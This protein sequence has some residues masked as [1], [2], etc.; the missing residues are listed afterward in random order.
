MLAR[1]AEALGWTV[2]Y[3]LEEV[4]AAA[5]QQGE[6]AAMDVA[7]ALASMSHDDRALVLRLVQAWRYRRPETLG[8]IDA[9]ARG[10]E[11]TK[12]ETEAEEARKGPTPKR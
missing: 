1:W 3:D 9:I 6:A 2:R 8:L 7:P 4:D 11:Q 5:L 10:M 12:A